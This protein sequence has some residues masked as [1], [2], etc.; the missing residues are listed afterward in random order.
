VAK[1]ELKPELVKFHW[2]QRD[3]KTGVT[4]VTSTDLDE[5]GAFRDSDWPEDFDSVILSADS[6]YLDA[7]A[8][9]SHR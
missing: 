6:A 8:E 4:K 9:R 2:F 7:V 1:G 5:N 3:S